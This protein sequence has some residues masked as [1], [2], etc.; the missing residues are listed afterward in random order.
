MNNCEYRAAASSM[1]SNLT[2]VT[3]K[4]KG[5]KHNELVLSVESRDSA[6]GRRELLPSK[7]QLVTNR[8][9]LPK[10]PK[11]GGTAWHNGQCAA[12]RND[13][14]VLTAIHCRDGVFESTRDA[15]CSCDSVQ[16]HIDLWV[17]P[18]TRMN[19]PNPE[20]AFLTPAT[21][22]SFKR[23]GSVLSAPFLQCSS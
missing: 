20:T 17:T 15:H 8:S 4:I 13:L 21:R 10:Q 11:H 2:G 19:Y 1:L 23:L 9:F 3:L 7:P 14:T 5:E 6:Q 16:T 12:P 22:Y 18:F